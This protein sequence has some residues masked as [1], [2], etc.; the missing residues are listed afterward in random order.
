TPKNVQT[1]AER[2]KLVYKVKVMIDNPRQE[3]KPGMPADGV[4]D[5]V[6]G[7]AGRGAKTRRPRNNGRTGD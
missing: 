2:V 7:P 5:T 1:Q 4:I 6:T 3:L